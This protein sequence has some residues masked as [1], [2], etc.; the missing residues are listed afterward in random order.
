MKIP[1]RTDRLRRF[2]NP[3]TIAVV[4]ASDRPGSLG[5]R[6]MQNLANFKGQVFPVSK[7]LKTLQGLRCY[8]TLADLPVSPDCVIL[9]VPAAAVQEEVAAAAKKNAAGCIVFA[10]G[11]EEVGTEEGRAAQSRLVEA[12]Q[13]AGMRLLGPNTTGFADFQSGARAGFAEFPGGL[14]GRD[15]GVAVVSQSGALGLALA[16]ASL[17]GVAL[18][19]VM[20]C[21][22][23][24]DIDVAD[25]VEYLASSVEAAAIA[26]TFEGVSDPKK[27]VAAVDAAIQAGK[28]VSVCRIGRSA[29]GAAA[30]RWHTATEPHSGFDWDQRL[31]RAGAVL[32]DQP[33]HL[34]ETANFL[35][36]TAGI[37]RAS[38]GGVAILS[39]SGGSAIHAADCLSAVG[40]D[41]AG[42]SESTRS[43]LVAALPAFGSPR[44]P[45]DLTAQAT[46]DPDMMTTAAGILLQDPSVKALLLPWGKAWDSGRFGQLSDLAKHHAKPVC[47]IWMSQWLEGPG[48]AEAEAAPHLCVFRSAMSC[49]TALAQLRR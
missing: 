18:S 38:N 48:A 8:G 9:A 4:G 1:S 25:L 46:S 37:E 47:L 33:E 23:S 39:S 12:A 2:L 49:A 41:L 30:A 40:L 29:T 43:H 19:H 15:A 11:Y 14:A 44:N 16:Q 7:R 5:L 42:Y 21:G 24:A 34:I 13:A 45:C 20:T 26:L 10:A 28:G 27:L 36:K 35:A 3:G 31:A 17:H 6:T 32:V 22:N